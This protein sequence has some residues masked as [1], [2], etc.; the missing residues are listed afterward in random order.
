MLEFFRKSMLGWRRVS[1]RGRV[2]LPVVLFSVWLICFGLLFPLLWSVGWTL[3]EWSLVGSVAQSYPR[4]CAFTTLVTGSDYVRG[5]RVLAFSLALHN[6]R[7]YPLVALTVGLSEAE[8]GRLRQVGWDVRPVQ[9]IPFFPPN[10]DPDQWRWV[11]EK[12]LGGV[13]VQALTKMRIWELTEFERVVFIDADAWVVGDVSSHLCRR[14]EEIVGMGSPHTDVNSGVMSLRPSKERFQ[15]MMDFWEKEPGK[16]FVY[17]KRNRQPNELPNPDQSLIIGYCNYRKI[18][19]GPLSSR[20]N[21]NARQ[22]K[23]ANT[24]IVHFNVDV[25]KPWKMTKAKALSNLAEARKAGDYPEQVVWE[26]VVEWLQ[27]EEN[28]NLLFESA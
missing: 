14:T 17:A 2:P 27:L 7:Q 1:S 3:V 12:R 23:D 9:P 21:L 15:D 13:H 8:E 6:H 19:I 11:P 5:A 24:R 20:Y 16:F 4:S 26:Y 18:P 28:L 22:A 10:R 25:Y